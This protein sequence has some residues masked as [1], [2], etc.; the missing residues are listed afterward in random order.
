MSE[1]IVCPACR[2]RNFPVASVCASCRTPLQ[3][4][5]PGAA[6]PGVPPPARRG[7]PQWPQED[8]GRVGPR[9]TVGAGRQTGPW[10]APPGTPAG[11]AVPGGFPGAPGGPASPLAD[12]RPVQP[13]PDEEAAPTAKPGICWNCGETNPRGREYCVRCRQRLVSDIA[14][15]EEG[16]R[17]GR[18]G[19]KEP[20]PPKELKPP[21]EPKP[22]N[23]PTATNAPAAEPVAEEA[24]KGRRGR[25]PAPAAAASAAA[26]TVG[27]PRRRRG[28]GGLI[29]ALL[30]IVLVLVLAG[31]AALAALRIAAVLPR[32]DASPTPAGSAAPSPATSALP[33]TV[34]TAAPTPSPAPSVAPTE[35]ATLPPTASPATT[36]APSPTATT[37]PTPAPTPTAVPT[38]VPTPAGT[39]KASPKVAEPTDW[40]C[41]GSATITDPVARGW[42]LAEVYTTGRGAYDRVTLRLVPAPERDGVT[43]NATADKV[44]SDA[45]PR[46]GLTPPAA[47]ANAILVGFNEPV[48]ALREQV[49]APG[50]QAVK[51]LAIE[52]SDDGRTW[53]VLGVAGQGC[54]QLR[55]PEWRD[56][57]SA[58]EPFIDITLD[59]RH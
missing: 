18:R 7:E 5:G 8:L 58:G 19:G 51:S 45:V 3:R 2:A 57:S 17:R 59:V 40:R 38:P 53:V 30:K 28:C 39:P 55:A 29:R 21:K 6:T 12:A 52:T 56:A 50:L 16:K 37:A 22:G 33:S 10:P 25:G 42:T 48:A 23:E 26:A 41:T 11:G 36:T 34:P 4:P 47:G 43:T 15:P 54:F 20:K 9:S 31:V 46:R 35:A 14:P 24:K 32:T 27:A 44:A 49:L 13:A 1:H